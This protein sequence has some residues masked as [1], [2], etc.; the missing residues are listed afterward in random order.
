MIFRKRKKIIITFFVLLT[1]AGIYI[2][3]LLKQAPVKIPRAYGVTFSSFYAEEF[4]LDWHKAY[5]ALFEDLGVRHVRLPAYWNEVEQKD[6][7]FDF[8]R[9]DWQVAEAK[10]YHADIILAVGRKLPRWPECHIP[11]WAINLSTQERN[12]KLGGY[13]KATVEHY[14]NESAITIWQVENEPF[15]PFGDCIDKPAS[16]LDSEIALVKSLDT[17]RPIMITDSGELSLWIAAA[18]RADIFGST[19]YRSVYNKIFGYITYPLPPAFF[20]LKQAFTELVVGKKPM[21][22]VE[23]QGEPWSREATYKLSVEDHYKTMNPDKFKEALSYASQTGFD[24]F[25]LW[26]AEWWYW[27]KTTQQK[28]EMWDIAKGAIERTQ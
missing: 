8:S 15:L 18:R 16:T 28:P 24:T 4:G 17:S 19:M 22:V 20:R 12:N 2:A 1:G 26:G 10:K 14:K 3:L 5:T 13:I 6:D 21:I 27:L 9:L 23:L 25:Y 11:A 7:V